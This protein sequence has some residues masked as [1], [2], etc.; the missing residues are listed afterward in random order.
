MKLSES[1]LFENE[2]MKRNGYSDDDISIPSEFD[3]EILEQKIKDRVIYKSEESQTNSNEWFKQEQQNCNSFSQ[4][5]FDNVTRQFWNKNG[6]S[7]WIMKLGERRSLYSKFR[8]HHFTYCDPEIREHQK[9]VILET[10]KLEHIRIARWTEVC[11]FA[12]VIGMTLSYATAQREVL[13]SV[14]PRVCIVDEASEIPEAQLMSL[15][16]SNRLEHLIMF[17]D[18]QL[19]RPDVKSKTAQE[20]GLDVSLFERWIK[21][22]RDHV[23]LKQQSR[24]HPSVHELVRTLY[25]NVDPTEHSVAQNIP[26]ILGVPSHVFF[27][28]HDNTDK[29]WKCFKKIN[30]FEAKF[31]ASFA[32]YLYQQGYDPAIIT[33]LTPYVDQQKLIWESLKP[34]LRREPGQDL[35]YNLNGR[36]DKEQSKVG[37]IQVKLLDEYNHDENQIVLLSLVAV[38]EKWHDEALNTLNDKKRVIIALSRALH[39]LYIFGNEKMLQKSEVW[40][41][42]IKK[43]KD[44][45]KRFFYLN[46]F[47]I[48]FKEL[49]FLPI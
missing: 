5:D 12:P 32:F 16:S 10:E 25:N 28:T 8:Q 35:P 34:E 39:A 27:M 6:K 15:V 30:T 7:I 17:G 1:Y 23:D 9:N 41:P 42:V 36:F 24:M 43:L 26:K 19:S 49:C 47:F 22:N 44:L 13:S 38:S 37:K 48:Q 14:K 3:K 4:S 46:N 11:N 31:V 40:A 33:I 20:H 18:N 29:N 2:Q 21:C 45:C